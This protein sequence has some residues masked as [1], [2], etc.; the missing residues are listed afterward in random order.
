MEAKIKYIAKDGR[1][2]NDPKMLEQY[3]KA[4]ET[5][6]NTIEFVVRMLMSLEGYVTGVVVCEHKGHSCSQPFVTVCVDDWLKDYVDVENLTIEQRYIDSSTKRCAAVLRRKFAMEDQCQYMLLLGKD[7]DM[8]DCELLCNS[9]PQ[10]LKKFIRH[11]R[12]EN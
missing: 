11:N 7:V 1:Q 12:D 2:F 8:K 4:L 5:D 6:R 10:L 3:E 9:N